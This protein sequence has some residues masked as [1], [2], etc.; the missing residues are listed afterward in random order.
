MLLVAKLP[1]FASFARSMD[2]TFL[3]CHAVSLIDLEGKTFVVEYPLPEEGVGRDLGV[4]KW[5]G[6]VQAFFSFIF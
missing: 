5:F 3:H 6:L 2:R 4:L 1:A